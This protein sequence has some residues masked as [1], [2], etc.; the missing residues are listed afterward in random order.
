MDYH[1]SAMVKGDVEILSEVPAKNGF[2]AKDSDD[3]RMFSHISKLCNFYPA[4]VGVRS[5][6]MLLANQAAGSSRAN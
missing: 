4:E 5:G 3:C 1:L 2:C 6:E